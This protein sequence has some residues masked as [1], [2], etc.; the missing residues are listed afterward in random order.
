MDVHYGTHYSEENLPDFALF[1]SIKRIKTM[2][3]FGVMSKTTA[4]SIQNCLLYLLAK[5]QC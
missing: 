2:T 4:Y 5:S 1:K 3:G